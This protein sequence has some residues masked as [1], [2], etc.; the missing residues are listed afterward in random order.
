MIYEKNRLF[1][2]TKAKFLA[3]KEIIRKISKTELIEFWVDHGIIVNFLDDISEVR[4]NGGGD[5][6]D[7]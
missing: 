4:Y 3:I 1:L 5:K 7:N 6:N 2:I